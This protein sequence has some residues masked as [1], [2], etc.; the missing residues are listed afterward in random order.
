VSK[1][2]NDDGA[3]RGGHYGNRD[4]NYI[5]ERLIDI[6]VWQWGEESYGTSYGKGS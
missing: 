2:G 6:H 5:Y 1:V 4:V 3:S